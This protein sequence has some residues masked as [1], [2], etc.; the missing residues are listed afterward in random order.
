MTNKKISLS[1]VHQIIKH[2]SKGIGRKKS[3]RE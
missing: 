1:K 2:Q 3:Q